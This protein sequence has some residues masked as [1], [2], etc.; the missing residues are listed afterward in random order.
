MSG[1]VPSGLNAT[2]LATG[3]E[4]ETV[5]LWDVKTCQE[6]TTLKGHARE[7]FSVVFHW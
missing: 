7:V 5:K 6:K 4:D 2:L 1:A 3:S